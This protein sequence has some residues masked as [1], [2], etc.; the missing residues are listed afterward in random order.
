[1]KA[2]FD[3]TG[4]RK[5]G[6]LVKANKKTVWVK[7]PYKKKISEEGAKAIY[8]NFIAIIKRHKKKHNVIIEGDAK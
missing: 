3:L 5:T 2:E 7:F 8:Q 4:Q 1:M 6:D